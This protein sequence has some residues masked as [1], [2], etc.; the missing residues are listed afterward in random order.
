MHLLK[1]TYILNSPLKET[2]EFFTNSKT[3]YDW[4]KIKLEGEFQVNNPIKFICYDENGD[5][6]Q[7][8][9]E[10]MIWTGIISQYT[11][12][13]SY[14]AIYDNPETTGL[15]SETYEVKKIADYTTELNIAQQLISL[16]QYNQYDQGMDQ[17][18]LQLN[19]YIQA[20]RKVSIEALIN[21]PIKEVYNKYNNEEDIKNWSFADPSWECSKANNNLTRGKEFHYTM[22][23]KDNSVSFDFWG[24]YLDIIHNKYIKYQMGDGRIAEIWFE[25]KDNQTRVKI[26]FYIES[27]N[28]KELQKQGWQSI[29]NNFKNYCER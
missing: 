4:S 12:N 19:E 14:T 1:K 13:S 22:N 26:S 11:K 7:Y 3:M 27:E 18:I 10:S 16:D 6:L 17:M 20:Q 21:K 2:F 25:Q 28:S 15:I 5:I 8:N 9:G 29:L 24:T 23:A